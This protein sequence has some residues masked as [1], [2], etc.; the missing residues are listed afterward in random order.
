MV[1]IL[2]VLP[3]AN[4]EAVRRQ[5]A[6]VTHS[7][8]ALAL[9]EG[10]FELDNVARL[11]LLQR[12]AQIQRRQLALITRQES[13][14]KLAQSLG[15]PVFIEAQ[16]AQR[17]KWQMY[18][19]LPLVE[20]TQPCRRACP[21]RLPGDAPRLSRASARPSHSPNTPTPHPRRRSRSPPASRLAALCRL[22]CD[23]RHRGVVL[24]FFVRN[25]LPAATI[26]LVPGRATMTRQCAP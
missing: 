20:P 14:R 6:R 11:R 10:W 15:I 3:H 23:G 8:V 1:E 17:R 19:D 25:V 26:T 21:K 22:S 4:V 9:P 24:S 12:Q 7:H 2:P 13:T 16:D 18:P 5:M